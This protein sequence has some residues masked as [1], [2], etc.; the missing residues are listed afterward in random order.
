MCI[1]KGKYTAGSNDRRGRAS[2]KRHK[3]KKKTYGEASLSTKRILRESLVD[4]ERKF[5]EGWK[6]GDEREDKDKLEDVG[7]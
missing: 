7:E 5:E 4:G 2:I 1:Q 6:G 3:R